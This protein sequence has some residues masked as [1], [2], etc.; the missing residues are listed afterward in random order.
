MIVKDWINRQPITIFEIELKKLPGALK[1][2]NPVI[3]RLHVRQNAI[4]VP[5]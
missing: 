4:S 1:S 3:S 5:I 2:L